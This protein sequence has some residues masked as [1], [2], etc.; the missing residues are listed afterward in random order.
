MVRDGR[1][2]AGWTPDL[3]LGQQVHGSTLGI[4]GLGRIGS[5]VARRAK[6][7]GM[8]V[9]YYA[10]SQKEQEL[11]TYS[12]LDELLAKSDF[13]SIHASMNGASRHL[14]DKE[15]LRKMKPTA[16]LINTSRGGIVNE[17]DLVAALRKGG[18]AGAGLD[19]FEKEPLSKKSPLAR[20]KNVVL[21]PHIGSASRQTRHRMAQVAVNCVLDALDGKRPDPYFLVNPQLP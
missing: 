9:L 18:I 6:G 8:N 7:F 10:R 21:L 12:G 14:I 15:K 1:W 3:L 13:V 19:V 5:A 4:I 20:M 2:K 11:A 17:R 16:F